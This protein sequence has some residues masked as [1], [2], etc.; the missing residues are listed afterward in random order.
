MPA[1]DKIYLYYKLALARRIGFARLAAGER[2]RSRNCQLHELQPR[3]L[4]MIFVYD[5][6]VAGIITELLELRQVIR[7]SLELLL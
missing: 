6:R 2:A 3:I 7:R 5:H 4:R 1:M